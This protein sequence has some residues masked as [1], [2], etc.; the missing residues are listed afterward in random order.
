VRNVAALQQLQRGDGM[1]AVVDGVRIAE[2]P[3]EDVITIEGNSYFPPSSLTRGVFSESVM[4][5]ICPWKGVARYYDVS[6]GAGRHRDAAW[7]YPAP[8]SSAID[9]V[10]RD[11]SG[12][13]AFDPGQVTIIL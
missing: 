10:G 7:C 13:V 4:P 5:Y 2:S 9:L 8:R 3:D 1:Q 11:F 6:T 12:Y